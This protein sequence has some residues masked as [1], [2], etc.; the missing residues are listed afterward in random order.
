M[1]VPITAKMTSV[2]TVRMAVCAPP[3]FQTGL[4]PEWRD[5]FEN[6]AVGFFQID[7]DGYFLNAN[8]KFCDIAGQP[9]SVLRQLR[10]HDLVHPGDVAESTESC[11]HLINVRGKTAVEKRYRR[12]DKT[13]AWV[14]ET[15]TFLLDQ[16]GGESGR[17]AIVQDITRL[18]ETEARLEEARQSLAAQAALARQ[19][20]TLLREADHRIKNSLQ[21]VGSLLY[22]Q[23]ARIDEPAAKAAFAAAS[24]QVQAIA[25]IHDRLSRSDS[26]TQVEMKSYLEQLCDG[27]K[28]AGMIDLSSFALTLDVEK[29]ELDADRA[30]ALALIASELLTNVLKHAFA[31]GRIVN[32]RLGLR[33][34]GSAATFT[35]RDDGPGLETTTGESPGGLGTVLLYRL[36]SQLGAKIKTKSSAN[37]VRTCLVFRR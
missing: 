12:P 34:R 29:F 36:A 7:R 3:A 2:K 4:V 22:L 27:L 16:C 6:S 30:V 21:M 37:G 5:F 11:E 15:A 28:R 25:H 13:S 19:K 26:A 24:A 35:L 17:L 10:Y 32:I 14:L 18:K 33:F 1:A 20:D 31:P 9:L 8:T 23:A